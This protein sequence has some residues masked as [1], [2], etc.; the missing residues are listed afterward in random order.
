MARR[1]PDQAAN[2]QH[3]TQRFQ[4]LHQQFGARESLPARSKLKRFLKGYLTHSYQSTND[5]VKVPAAWHTARHGPMTGSQRPT[6]SAGR[7]SAP[8][9]HGMPLLAPSWAAAP[10]SEE[11]ARL[12]CKSPIGKSAMGMICR[13][14]Y[15]KYQRIEPPR[16]GVSSPG[17]G[18]HERNN[19]RKQ[20]S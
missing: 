4:L 18:V 8:S 6:W 12:V 5:Q 3:I 15:R 2:N 17:P 10:L 9:G 19:G 14:G 7:C 16:P 1:L 11:T 13:R 20:R